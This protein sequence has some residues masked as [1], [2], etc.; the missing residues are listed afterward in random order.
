MAIE[1]KPDL[2]GQAALTLHD[3]L[4]Q[5]SDNFPDPRYRP[6]T[7]RVNSYYSHPTFNV[8]P[9]KLA[10]TADG[11]GTKPE[12]AERLIEVEKK[13]ELFEG[14][15][16][17]VLSMIEGDTSR[18]GYFLI[19]AA[20]I[21]DTNIAAPAMIGAL[22]QGLKKACD[23]GQFPLVA[24][25]TAELDYRTSGYGSNRLNWNAFGVMMIVAGKE[26][27]GEALKSG[28]PLV[29]LREISIR[30]N[31]LTKARAILEAAYLHQLGYS[32]KKDYLF[33]GLEQYFR[34]ERL[35]RKRAKFN[36]EEILGVLDD[37]LGHN[38]LEQ[39]LVPWHEPGFEF[40]DIAR[41]LLR[42]STLY[43]RL[44]YAAQ[45][46]VDGPREIDITAAA[47]ISGGGVPEK[48]K[49]MVEAKGLGAD[50]RAVFPDPLAVRQLMEIAQD[51]PPNDKGEPIITHRKACEQWHRG[52]GF[53]MATRT[54]DDAKRLVDLADNLNYEAAIVGEITS[55]PVINW[56]GETWKYNPA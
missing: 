15:A 34:D 53:I 27:T 35:F 28:Q 11:V 47:H 36:G 33:K 37:F 30:S 2:K 39:M 14:L 44:M 26:I 31:G 25:E 19:G 45:G 12:I 18:W 48:V 55:E 41:E 56:R 43:G 16:Y 50:I 32:S 8:Y 4:D 42:P 51:L 23:E 17:D 20:N 46:G 5:T 38:F 10:I 1:L 22:A 6:V 29:A 49:R 7:K 40:A 21:I 24:G 9:H 3:V 13:P 52:I 54:K